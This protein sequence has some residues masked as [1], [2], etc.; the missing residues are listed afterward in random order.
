MPY[1]ILQVCPFLE[2][3]QVTLKLKLGNVESV[4]RLCY[5][6]TMLAKYRERWLMECHCKKTCI[7]LEKVL[8]NYNGNIER[9]KIPS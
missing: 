1:C 7:E 3:D 9:R 4:R 2:N 6:Y 5:L 8:R